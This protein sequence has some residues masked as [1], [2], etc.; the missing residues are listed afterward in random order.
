VQNTASTGE[1]AGMNEFCARR[2]QEA[3]HAVPEIRKNS[4]F[5]WLWPAIHWS[6]RLK[7]AADAGSH[8]AN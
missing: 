2:L 6:F 5:S 4:A 3:C 8:Y 7:T 1:N